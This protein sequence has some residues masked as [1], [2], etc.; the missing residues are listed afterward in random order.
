MKRPVI[1]FIFTVMIFSY[2]FAGCAQTADDG[3][4]GTETQDIAADA[5]TEEQVLVLNLPDEHYGGYDFRIMTKGDFDVHWKSRDIYAEDIT[6]DALNDAVYERN[7]WLSEEYGVQITDI[8]VSDPYGTGSKSVLAGADDYDLIS[9]HVASHTAS[10]ETN[11]LL[12]DLH[13]IPYID[14][15]KPY[16]DQ[17]SVE[18]LSVINKLYVVTGDMITMDNDATWVVLFNK[19]I[20][21]DLNFEAQYGTDF[22]G[23]VNDLKWTHYI[24]YET[25]RAAAADINGD[26]KM[27]ET[28]QW[29]LLSEGFNAYALLVGS[30]ITSF[31]KDADDYPYV[32][33]YSDTAYEILDKAI[34]LMRDN[35][36]TMYVSDWTSKFTDVWTDCMDKTFSDGRAL[37]NFAGL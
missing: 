18:S 6:G 22:Y 26:G 8:G 35:T 29:G 33:L 2:I 3:A 34:T 32:S 23:L 21:D 11:N 31:S 17:N 19:S 25:V 5:E 12:I 36:V 20:T 15:S 28:D 9:V 30:G 16:Y 1:L 27:D 4:V 13:E 7:L 37:Y 10:Y 14:L 24:F